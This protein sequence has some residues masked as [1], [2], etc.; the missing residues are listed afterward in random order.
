MAGTTNN[1]LAIF[2]R[3]HAGTLAIRADKHFVITRN[4]R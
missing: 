2:S 4:S 1:H 3:I